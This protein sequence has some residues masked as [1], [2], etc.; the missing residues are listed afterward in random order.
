M[1]PL[2]RAIL[3]HVHTA[4]TCTLIKLGYGLGSRLSPSSLFPHPHNQCITHWCLPFIPAATTT[5]HTWLIQGT[6]F[7]STA[8]LPLLY[9]PKT[10]CE[11]TTFSKK[12]SAGRSSVH[13]KNITLLSLF[14]F[15]N[16]N[17]RIY[18][19]SRTRML[20]DW[21]QKMTLQGT[22]QLI[23]TVVTGNVKRPERTN[24]TCGKTKYTGKMNRGFTVFSC[25]YDLKRQTSHK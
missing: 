16:D 14:F 6:V 8:K 4:S 18:C 7:T 21:C 25:N 24:N 1:R 9:I 13:S 17:Y 12:Y 22:M 11:I 3:H 23:Y 5:F 20:N 10:Q 2:P 15:R 19:G